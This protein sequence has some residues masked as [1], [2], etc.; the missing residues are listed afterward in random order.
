L[1]PS[2]TIKEN[3]RIL[4]ESYKKAGGTQTTLAR[5]TGVSQG[6]ISVWLKGGYLPGAENLATLATAFSADVSDFYRPPDELK[7]I[8]HEQSLRAG[9]VPPRS[10]GTSPVTAGEFKKLSVPEVLQAYNHLSPDERQDIRNA[11]LAEERGQQEKKK[12]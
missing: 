8:L 10:A 9:T 6:Q 5:I 7:R 11:L 4:F 12:R 3:L 2:E 1:N